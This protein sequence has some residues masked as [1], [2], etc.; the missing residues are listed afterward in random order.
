[1]P[2]APPSPL[3][4]GDGFPDISADLAH[5]TE[6]D[7]GPAPQDLGRFWCFLPRPGVL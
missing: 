1:M 3:E 5:H 2:S 4:P 6:S 7:P